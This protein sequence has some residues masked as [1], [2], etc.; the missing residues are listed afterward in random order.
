M[1]V[2]NDELKWDFFAILH[3]VDG[4]NEHKGQALTHSQSWNKCVVICKRCHRI[5]H[6]LSDTLTHD[7]VDI[8]LTLRE[9]LCQ[10]ESQKSIREKV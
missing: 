4:S 9:K 2:C 5:L 1:C 8:L 7:Q 3:H 6:T 10:K